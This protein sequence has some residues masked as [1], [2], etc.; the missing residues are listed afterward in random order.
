MDYLG[1]NN[2]WYSSDYV[3]QQLEYIFVDTAIVGLSVLLRVPQADGLYVS[4]VGFGKSNFVAKP[5][6]LAEQW[7]NLVLQGL[8]EFSEFVRL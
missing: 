8:G 2:L 4:T 3:F 1:G 7:E 6:L 5:L